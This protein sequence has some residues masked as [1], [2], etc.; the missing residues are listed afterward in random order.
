VAVLEQTPAK[1]PE[2]CHRPARSNAPPNLS[3]I[4]WIGPPCPFQ[5]RTPA[6]RTGGKDGPY[7]VGLVRRSRQIGRAKNTSP[8]RQ[9]GP[10]LLALRA[11]VEDRLLNSI[12][13]WPAA[14]EQAQ[15]KALAV[16]VRQAEYCEPVLPRTAGDGRASACSS[17]AGENAECMSW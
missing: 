16:P 12:R 15:A 7:T 4:A 6:I 2:R 14:P 10:A 9:Q 17:S 5:S 13:S 1:G 8:Q 3:K 11:G